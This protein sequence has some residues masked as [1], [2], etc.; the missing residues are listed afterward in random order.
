MGVLL[1]FGVFHAFVALSEKLVFEVSEDMFRVGMLFGPAREIPFEAILGRRTMT[2]SGLTYPAIF[3]DDAGRENFV[4]VPRFCSAD[5]ILLRDTI[6]EMI[7]RIR[8]CTEA[9]E[10]FSKPT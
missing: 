10:A 3:W 9:R 4:V 1:G 5:G 7:H 6:P 2:E 8:L